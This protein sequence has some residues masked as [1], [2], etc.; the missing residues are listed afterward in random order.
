MKVLVTGGTGY[1][2]SHTVAALLDTAHEVRLLVRSPEKIAPALEPLGAERGK[3]EFEVGD[4]T[5][6][7]SVERAL[8]GCDAAIHSASMYSLDRRDAKRMRRVNLLGAEIVLGTA[9]SLGLDPIVHVSSV[10]AILP[11]EEGEILTPQSAVKKPP[12]AYLGSKADSERIA[13]RFQEDGY[14]VVIVYPGGVFG[15]HDPGIG[16]NTRLIRLALRS[17]V[18][19]LPGGGINVVDVRDLAQVHARIIEPGKGPRRYMAG[20]FMTTKEIT[21]AAGRVTGRDLRFRKIPGPIALAVGRVSDVLQRVIPA[22]IPA[23]HEGIWTLLV[24]ARIDDSG[25]WEPLGV[26]PRPVEETFTDTIRWMLDV[27]LI[28][29]KHAGTLAA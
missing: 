17:P 27:G 15:P 2:G 28:E 8:T 24:A 16:E 5:D 18:V 29:P 1:V 10:A 4:V 9:A 21:E 22:R 7:P 25:T 23:N 3:V 26:E 19:A 20:R 6:R 12:G 13:R 14:P 11:P